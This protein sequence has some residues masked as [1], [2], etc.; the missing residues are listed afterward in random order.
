[1]NRRP[2]AS[3]LIELRLGDGAPDGV[4]TDALGCARRFRGWIELAG[5]IEEWRTQ[6]GRTDDRPDTDRGGR[7]S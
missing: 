4:L 1:M 2:T 6:A 3:A 7:T 5:A